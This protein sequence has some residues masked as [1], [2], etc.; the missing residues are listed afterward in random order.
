[1]RCAGVDIGSRTVKLVIIDDG[2]VVR[3]QVVYNSHD[4]LEIC[5]GLLAS[6]PCDR[7]VVTGYGR[8]LLREH[9]GCEAVTEIRAVAVGAHRVHPTA[10]TL[11]D[12]GG[13]DTKAI[14]ID[15][16]GRAGRFVMNDK[17]AAGTGRFLEMAAQ[18]L[19]FTMRSFIAAAEAATT[20]RRISPMCA[21]FAESEMVSLVG[22]GTP[23]DELALGIH[24]GIAERTAAMVRPLLGTGEVLM[25][26]GGALNGC[27]RRELSALLGRPVR[28]PPQ[29][30]TLAALGC[31]LVAASAADLSNLADAPAS[32]RRE[33]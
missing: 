14:A 15:E 23:R 30:Q 2:A 24:R 11:V 18:A 33:P 5:D 1:M 4:P 19:S 16:Q 7:I 6:E 8:H 32:R 20:A 17:C 26:G 10:R 9:L 27:L 3:A 28:L 25:C 21:V 22:R 31:A 12:I 29:P 13:Q